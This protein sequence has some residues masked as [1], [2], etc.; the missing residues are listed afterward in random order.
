MTLEADSLRGTDPFTIWCLNWPEIHITGEYVVVERT[1]FLG[2]WQHVEVKLKDKGY[3]TAYGKT[4]LRD[5][6]NSP[7][8][9]RDTDIVIGSVVAA[10]ALAVQAA[11]AIRTPIC[12][13][14]D[15]GQPWMWGGEYYAGH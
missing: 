5:Y 10:D 8:D 9:I 4:F 14:A 3:L 2:G 7:T 1:L 6:A 11:Y 15:D 12:C 13:F